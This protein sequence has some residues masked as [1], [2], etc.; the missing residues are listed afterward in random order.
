MIKNVHRLSFEVP[1]ILVR[2]LI[3]GFRRVLDI[4]FFL[5]PAYEDGTNRVPKRRPVTHRRRGFTQK[6]ENLSDFN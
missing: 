6:K 3:L 5:S 4:V 1:G 2:F